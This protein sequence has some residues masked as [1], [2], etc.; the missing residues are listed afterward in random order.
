MV[1]EQLPFD[2]T[3]APAEPPPP[4]PPPPQPYPGFW[5]A[6]GLYLLFLLIQAGLMVPFLVVDRPFG[7]NLAKHPATYATA[8]LGAAV[9]V[10]W[11]ARRRF[12]MSV[13]QIAGPIAIPRQMIVPMGMAMIGQL[14]VVV[15]L[16][17][18]LLRLFPSLHS[19]RDYGLDRSLWGGFLLLVI[20]APLSE[21]LLFRGIFLRGFLPR[22]GTIRGILLGAL[23]FAAAH[24]SAIK[25]AGP[26]LMGVLF[27]WWFSRL[28][29]IWPGVFGHAFNNLIPV[30]AAS[31]QTASKPSRAA[32]SFGWGEPIIAL[33]G[34]MLLEH[35][36]RK[37]H[38]ILAAREAG[39][40]AGTA[41]VA[42]AG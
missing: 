9:F 17:I 23:F 40:D 13:R 35:G 31:L 42:A 14:M 8:T 1:P 28:H 10:L 15:M 12:S 41:G 27:G 21:E 7:L 18:W 11:T 3:D 24:F 6:V 29:S 38:R 39:T 36:V 25:L 2:A 34:A 5:Q 20:A 4:P 26:I 16:A 32:P 30:F 33:L 19:D 37:L 22:Y